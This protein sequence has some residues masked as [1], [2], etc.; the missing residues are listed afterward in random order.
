MPVFIGNGD[1]LCGFY[2]T[3]KPSFEGYE[4]LFA[5]DEPVRMTVDIHKIELSARKLHNYDSDILDV[6]Q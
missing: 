6:D 3:R 2:D 5:R 4:F 1:T